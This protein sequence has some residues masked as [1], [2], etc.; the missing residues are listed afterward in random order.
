MGDSGYPLLPWLMTPIEQGGLNQNGMRRY[1]RR[2]KSTR[3]LV[4]CA[5]GQIKAKFP[6]LNYFRL[7]PEVAS[8]I[9]LACFI[10]HNIQKRLGSE[11]WEIEY[12]NS[13]GMKIF[14]RL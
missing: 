8:K 14:K 2:H 12:D 11:E 1:L 9:V 6:C 13:E 3:R 10:L 4:E 7:K 5:F